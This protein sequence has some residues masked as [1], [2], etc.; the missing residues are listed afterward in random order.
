MFKKLLNL[1]NIH[2]D[3]NQKWLLISL[4]FSG[5]LIAN[6]N[7]TIT[8]VESLGMLLHHRRYWMDLCVLEKSRSIKK[9]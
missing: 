5:L 6:V 2:P 8:K 1:L 7:P 9:N 4:F 3:E